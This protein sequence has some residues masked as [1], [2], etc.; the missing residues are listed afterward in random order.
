MN[1]RVV[2]KA[3]LLDRLWPG[4]DVSEASLTTCVRGLRV[5]LDDRSR[6]GGYL[7]T[8][9]GRGYRFHASPAPGSAAGVRIAVA[10]FDCADEAERYL[11]EGLAGEV[12]AGL[13][14]WRDDGIEAIARG[15]AER[16]WEHGPDEDAFARDLDLDFVVSGRVTDD[17]RGLEVGR[18][19]GEHGARFR[20][21]IALRPDAIA[22]G[23]ITIPV[24]WA[25]EP[26]RV[27][28][29]RGDGRGEHVV[30]LLPDRRIRVELPIGVE[31]VYVR[32]GS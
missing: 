15:S 32:V 22:A 9:H 10:P 24:T 26:G 21:A 19:D 7:E 31:A 20:G 23:D 8:V 5:A 29:I 14:C 11:A 25:V 6:R 17:S 2:S 27:R 28:A 13:H 12:A 3:E 18:L 30:E 16:S 4:E 1:G